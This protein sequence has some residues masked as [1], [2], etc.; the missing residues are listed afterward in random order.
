MHSST[1]QLRRKADIDLVNQL[2]RRAGGLVQLAAPF[3]ANSSQ[4]HLRCALLSNANNEYPASKT[5]TTTIEL[6]IQFPARYPFEAPVVKIKHRHFHPNVFENGT[7]CLGSKWLASE[8]LDLF[9]TRVLRLLTYDPWLVNLG[10]P[11]NGPAANWYRQTQ[12]AYPTYFPTEPRHMHPWLYDP[13]AEKAVIRCPHC[14]QGLRLPTG[15]HG[16]VQC[17]GCKQD[18]ETHT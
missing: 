3:D 2:L 9:I 13:R 17:P 12:T 7:V 10:S 16:V 1:A 8:S 15:R 18:F 14:N 6:V 5:A 11:A 4:L